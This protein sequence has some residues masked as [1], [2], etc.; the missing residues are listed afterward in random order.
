[1]NIVIDENIP[2]RTVNELRALGHRVVD[3]RQ[4]PVRAGSDDRLWTFAQSEGALLITT[5]KGFSLKWAE[6]HHGVLI[7]RLRQPNREKIHSRVM[8][9]IRSVPSAEWAGLL[10]VM[11]D[12]VQSSRRCPGR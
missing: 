8:L 1:M 5:D 9:A 2:V 11:R 12:A 3:A 7:I 4:S 10:L 6:P